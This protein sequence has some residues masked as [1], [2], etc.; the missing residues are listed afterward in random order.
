MWFW[1][2]MCSASWWWRLEGQRVLMRR[3]SHGQVYAEHIG[4]SGLLCWGWDQIDYDSDDDDD[5]F[6]LTKFAILKVWLFAFYV[7]DMLWILANNVCVVMYAI[8][9]IRPHSLF[10]GPS[11]S[12]TLQSP[13]LS[14]DGPTCLPAA[15]LLASYTCVTY[16]LWRHSR[17]WF[18][19]TSDPSLA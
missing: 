13:S 11:L 8:G 4:M 15:V 2:K 1:M 3:V 19:W 14:L 5:D 7:R 9:H 6:C 18:E 10:A 12:L 17:A 16:L